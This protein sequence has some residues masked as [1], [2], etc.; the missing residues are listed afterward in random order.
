MCTVKAHELANHIPVSS[1]PEHLG[2]SL[3]YSHMAW[4]QSCFNTGSASHHSDA[5]DNPDCVGNLLR[6]YWP[7]Q[8]T[9][10]L[11]GTNANL[12]NHRNPTNHTQHWNGSA[13]QGRGHHPPP[14]SDTPPDTPIH[15]AHTQNTVVTKAEWASDGRIPD[16][17]EHGQGDRDEEEEE[18][19]GEEDGVPPLPQ[20]S[21]P[22]PPSHSPPSLPLE[23]MEVSV[24]M[25]ELGGMTVDELVAHVKRSRKRGIYQEY[26]QIR[27][28]PPTGTFT[29]SK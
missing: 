22:P 27:K 10:P 8:N 11:D 2:G 26:E 1:L 25:P 23:L 5:N 14:Q 15:H 13:L 20:K 12:P 19:E 29:Y 28:E 3:N 24:H 4:V 17:H 7:E 6:S 18:R 9:T 21:R 16:D